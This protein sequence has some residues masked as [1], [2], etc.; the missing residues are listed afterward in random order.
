MHQEISIKNRAKLLAKSDVGD[1]LWLYFA[2]N[3]LL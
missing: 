3:S 2:D 1:K